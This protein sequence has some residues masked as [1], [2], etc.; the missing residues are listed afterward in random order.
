[1]GFFG[2]KPFPP[3][4]QKRIPLWEPIYPHSKGIV[5]DDAS[6]S[7]SRLVGYATLQ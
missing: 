6:S 3:K 1:M 4:K 5:E 2:E 7:S